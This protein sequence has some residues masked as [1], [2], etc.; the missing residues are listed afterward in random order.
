MSPTGLSP[1]TSATARSDGSAAR[2]RATSSM[3]MP[4]GSGGTGST[5]RSTVKSAPAARVISGSTAISALMIVSPAGAQHVDG[6]NR[7]R[8]AE[9]PTLA[10][11]DAQVA[12]DAQLVL[13]LD[14][15]RDERGAEDLGKA[16]Q[17]AQGLDLD[18]LGRD[19]V[20]EVLVDLDELGAQFGP[21]SQAGPTVTEIVEREAQ[22]RGAQVGGR[23]HHARQVRDVFML[24]DLD[25]QRRRRDRGGVQ[26]PHHASDGQALD[27]LDDGERAQVEK[28]AGIGA[29]HG[30]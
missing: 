11:L 9:E 17:A 27:H 10:E 20:D 12:H 7:L 29:V 26:R 19:V 23:G 30:P 1:S 3:G 18:R 13:R 16:R 24:R 25:D 4:D 14:T 5:S 28:E 6:G 21:Q 2:R 8:L 15:F 22:S